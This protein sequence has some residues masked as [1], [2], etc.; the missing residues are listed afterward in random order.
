MKYMLAA[1]AFTLMQACP[2]VQKDLLVVFGGSLLLL[3]GFPHMFRVLWPLWNYPLT[4]SCC[5]TAA[6]A[7]ACGLISH[8]DLPAA[9]IE[10]LSSL[11]T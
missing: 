5:I 6:V 9:V 11:K 8:D 7:V 1:D 10:M 4:A 2:P 3:N